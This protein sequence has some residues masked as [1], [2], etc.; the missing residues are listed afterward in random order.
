MLMWRRG[1]RREEREE[2]QAV[3]LQQARTQEI[4]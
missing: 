3:N 1:E 2:K 4:L